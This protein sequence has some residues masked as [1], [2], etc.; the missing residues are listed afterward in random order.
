M[1][2]TDCKI[3]TEWVPIEPPAHYKLYGIDRAVQIMRADGMKKRQICKKLR[4]GD[5]AWR[6][7]IFEIRKQEAI[8]DM[9]RGR[10]LTDE[11]RER[12]VMLRQAGA[13]L[14]EISAEV[15]VS[16]SSVKHVVYGNASQKRTERT[17]SAPAAITAQ[18]TSDVPETVREAVRDSVS[19][20]SAAID[21]KLMQIKRMQQEIEGDR[22]KL[23]E[24]KNWLKEVENGDGYQIDDPPSTD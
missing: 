16:L 5:D 18:V 23:A 20:L 13:K 14:A 21:I 8:E 24:L 17:Q 19:K 6:D 1:L 22:T 11:E 2:E 12:I 15:G 7:A 3:P 9:A 10:N 4:I